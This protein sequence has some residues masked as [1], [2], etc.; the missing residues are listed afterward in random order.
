VLTDRQ[1]L[2]GF[3]E[4]PI[5]EGY[6]LFL[7]ECEV[8]VQA[9]ASKD[10]VLARLPQG[11]TQTFL[12]SLPNFLHPVAYLCTVEQQNLPRTRNNDQRGSCSNLAFFSGLA[13]EHEF[14]CFPNHYGSHHMPTSLA[15]AIRLEMKR[16]GIVHAGA[17]FTQPHA[18]GKVLPCFVEISATLYFATGPL[19][20]YP[21]CLQWQQF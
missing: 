10:S 20:V 8:F 1:L 13:G 5:P 3:L 9:Q 19:G 18:M 11:F 4:K 15:K 6:L 7:E 16:R 17:A 21:S 12:H 2:F 14:S